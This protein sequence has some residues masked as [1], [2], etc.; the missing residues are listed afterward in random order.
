MAMLWTNT[1]GNM[2][3]WG[4]AEPKLGNNPMVL[5]VP[6]NNGHVVL[7]FAQSLFSY[8]KLGLYRSS[9]EPLPFDGGFDSAGKL[10]RDAAEILTS[11]RPLPAGLWKGAGVSLLLDLIATLLSG[12]RSTMQISRQDAE[13]GVS[14]VFFA[15]SMDAV[16]DITGRRDALVDEII[17]DLQASAPSE[18]GSRVRYPGEQ[19]LKTRHENVQ[20][21]IPVSGKVWESVS[22]LL[23]PGAPPRKPR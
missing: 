2:P 20:L 22:A 12:G 6:R 10:S 16:I 17:A 15:V 19:T 1:V 4:G 11:K 13:Y 3:P 23:P 21:G 18:P 8:G 14:Q 7:D 9:R 5:A